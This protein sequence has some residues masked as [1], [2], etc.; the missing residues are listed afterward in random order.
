[1]KTVF[2]S[3][4]FFLSFQTLS[5]CQDGN[6]Q[7]EAV[8]IDQ[9]LKI[10]G[11]LD[12]EVY[13]TAPAATDFY[14]LGP[15]PGN[16][17]YQKSKVYF[18]YDQ[19]AIY[20]GAMLYDENPDS[21]FNY[22]SERDNIWAS[23]FFGIYFD[24]YNKGQLGFGFFINPAN[25]QADLKAVKSEYENEDSN[26]DAVWESET[27]ITDQGWIVEMR[28][29]WS[30]FRFPEN[31]SEAWGM[32]MFRNIK[33]YGS[34]NSWNYINDEVEGWMDQHGELTGIKDIT[35]PVRL[36]FSPYLASYVENDEEYRE[37]DV[38]FKGGMDLKY[39]L[40][41]SFTLDMMLIPDFGQIQSDDKQLNLSPYEIYYNEKRQF[42]NEG[43]EL[44]NRG[45]IFY[46]RRIGGYPKFT[47]DAEDQLRENEI[48]DFHPAQTQLANATKISG[49]TSN[50][51]GIGVLNAMS[52][53]TYSQ[54]RDTLTGNTRKV[55]S[56]P[57]TNYNVSVI[58]KSLANNSYISLINS[59]MSVANHDFMANVTATEFQLRDKKK[60][61]ALKG[62][63]AVSYR[64]ET[65][66]EDGY[67][68]ELQLKKNSGDWHFTLGQ[69][70]TTCDYNPNDLGYNRRNNAAQTEGSIFFFRNE[71]KWI[72]R[73]FNLNLYGHYNRHIKPA[74]E[75]DK[76]LQFSSFTRF[77]SNYT[78]YTEWQYQSEYHD[79]YK[80]RVDTMF[81]T[82]PYKYAG[83][84]GVNTD[85]RKKLNGYS[86]VGGFKKPQ[87]SEHGYWGNLG[88]NLKVGQRL[89]FYCHNYAEHEFN[90]IDF[91]D[92]ND[93][94]TEIY[95]ARRDI[96]RAEEILEISYT[97][98]NKASISLRE[99][100]YY[101]GVKNYEAYLLQDNGTLSRAENYETTNQNYL[102]F[103]IDM[104]FRW[105]FAPGS[106][107]VLAWK[108]IID[109]SQDMFIEGFNE[110]LKQT[111]VESNQ[112]NSVSLKI[113]YY[114]DYNNLRNGKFL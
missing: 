50:N 45:N 76:Y 34:H 31:T 64:G 59:N 41:E 109:D 44:F 69:D 88:I 77:M 97:F 33:R 14:Q 81:V 18:F 83:M 65:E 20:V 51:W 55:L 87:T 43:T 11:I 79:Y 46:S 98:N 107:L 101:S 37:T 1:M 22:L 106:E 49:R 111:F 61:F 90:D 104:A 12:E 114:L 112:V 66:K 6:K 54:L 103:N 100:Y 85:F 108:N 48:V 86:H 15:Y 105:I 67:F 62:K 58:D 3:A 63:G 30:A 53:N 93:N 95:F 19:T 24:P 42:F 91:Y 35:P 113:L 89:K 47:G 71:P 74:D 26:W 92:K 70:L 36:S 7:I 28:I 73:Y 72:V 23:D 102:A 78:F 52:L 8:I 10:D 38:L 16:P 84:A 40:S 99:R 29:P 57:F 60:R 27:N 25:V 96:T 13:L 94:N 82:V 80:T 9:P 39:G 5:I 68:G 17:A 32:N 21:I 75:M 2:L 4:L 56:Q 110:N